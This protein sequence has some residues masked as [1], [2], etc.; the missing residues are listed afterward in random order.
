MVSFGMIC[1]IFHNFTQDQY[2]KFNFGI[3]FFNAT[4]M[5][6]RYSANAKQRSVAS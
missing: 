1:L 4:Y 5:R 6:K 3:A 2:E